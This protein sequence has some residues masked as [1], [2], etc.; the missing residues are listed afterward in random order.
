M[1]RVGALIVAL[2][3][4]GCA[5][6]KK[7][8]AA[9]IATGVNPNAV[10]KMMS[11]VEWANNASGVNA[12]SGR[13]RAIA[14]M[15]EAVMIDPQLWEAH[16]DLGVLLAH[17]G[18]L[19]EAEASL[20]R[21]AKLAPATE[22]IAMALAQVRRRRG[23]HKEAADG[24]QLFTEQHP[25]AKEARVLYGVALRDS[26]QIDASIAQARESLRRKAGDASAL[27]EL[28]L[29]ELA[30]GER[31]SAELLVKEA[32]STNKESAV[33]HRT[34]GLIALAKGDDAAAFAS[35]LKASHLDPKDTT[36]RLN[37]G[38]VLVRAGVYAKAEEQFRAV[39]KDSNDD[40]DASIGLAAALR[41]QGDKDH[42]AKWNEAQKIL[43]S[44]LSRDPHNVAAEFNLAILLADFLKKPAEAKTLFQR[45]LA[46]A[47]ADH[48]AR[49]EAD[50]QVKA[51]GT[52]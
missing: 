29:S 43:E 2:S 39:L 38:T 51:V 46:D 41:G 35:F 28:A 19:A 11:G 27:S 22:E 18:D 49:A 52:K 14:L 4:A 20:E 30:K 9:P 10:A 36:A 47:P 15:R 25:E 34:A 7:P 8:P 16:Y 26:G 6:K 37:M 45:F 50:R 44:V 13:E 21:A 33:A 24:L 42:P 32:V 5:A 17:S 12:A 48:S 31:D 23:K 3:L 40:L 1:R